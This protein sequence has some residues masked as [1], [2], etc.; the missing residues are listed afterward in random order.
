MVALSE[1]SEKV[2]K[3]EEKDRKDGAKAEK[4]PLLAG[5]GVKSGSVSGKKE[6]INRTNSAE[7][8]ILRRL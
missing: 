2:T 8:F 7:G 3:K 1:C 4:Q 6:W 5:K